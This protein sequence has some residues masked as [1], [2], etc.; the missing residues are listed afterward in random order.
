MLV[1]NSWSATNG[2]DKDTSLPGCWSVVR[3]GTETT[4][5][6]PAQGNLLSKCRLLLVLRLLLLPS[7]AGLAS[8]LMDGVEEKRLEL[9][10]LEGLGLRALVLVAGELPELCFPPWDS[11]DDRVTGKSFKNTTV[12]VGCFVVQA[13]TS[14]HCP[15]TRT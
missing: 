12:S 14:N 9:G 10:H 3:L 13:C 7:R 6:R 5:G 2:G 4:E 15:R 1:A 8:R 11:G